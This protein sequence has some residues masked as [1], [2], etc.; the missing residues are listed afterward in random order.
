MLTTRRGFIGMLG[1]AA[2]TSYFFAP[3]G[4]WTSDVII[5]PA[6]LRTDTLPVHPS[7]YHTIAGHYHALQFDNEKLEGEPI[8]IFPKR[9]DVRRRKMSDVSFTYFEIGVGTAP[10]IISLG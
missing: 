1:A 6:T 9:S 8:F 10:R 7:G 2:A 4:G 3:V 5:N